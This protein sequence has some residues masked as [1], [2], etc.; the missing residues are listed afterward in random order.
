MEARKER[1][2]TGEKERKEAGPP[3]EQGKSFMREACKNIVGVVN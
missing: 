3:R 1:G 2:R